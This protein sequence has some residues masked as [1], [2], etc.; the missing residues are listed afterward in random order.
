MSPVVGILL[1]A[2]ETVLRRASPGAP[3]GARFGAVVFVHRAAAR[4]RGMAKYL[5][6]TPMANAESRAQYQR[7]WNT[8]RSEGQ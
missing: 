2:V 1:R 6:A 4:G 3:A 8:R 7:A 5:P